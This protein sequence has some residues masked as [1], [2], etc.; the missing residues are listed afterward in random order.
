MSSPILLSRRNFLVRSTFGLGALAFGQLLGGA[1]EAAN[2]TARGPFP[3]HFP[4]RAKRVIFL[5]QSGGPSQI[6]LLDYKPGLKDH[7]DQDLPDSIRMGQR[8][9]G[10]VSGQARLPV[11]PSKY[12]FRQCG[13]NGAWIGD[14]LPHTQKIADDICVINSMNTEAI[15]HDPA[16]TFIQTGSQQPGRP[17]M[18]S[19]VDYGLGSESQNLPS[20]VVLISKGKAKAAA[21]GLVA[22]LWGS[23]FLP[24]RHQGVKLRSKGDPILYLSD[25]DGIDP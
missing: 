6:E 22:R 10:M 7:F 15:N 3:P 8:I 5:F 13:Q 24:T 18:G 21:Q 16:I 9:T 14:L 19:W 25:P 20:F 11:A 4:A 17:S 23:G 2:S 12:A 1:T